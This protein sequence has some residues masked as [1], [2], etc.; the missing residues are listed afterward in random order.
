MLLSRLFERAVEAAF[1]APILLVSFV[2]T[3]YFF[4]ILIHRLVLS[5]VAKYP[6]PK[7]AAAT[8][9]YEFYFDVV[10]RGSYF[11][12]IAKMHQKYGQLNN[13]LLEDASCI[14]ISD[15]VLSSE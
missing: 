11:R 12:E 14:K 2:L 7:L 8:F 1:N 3:A 5:P 6:G 15:K 9:W 10:K 13:N 4:G